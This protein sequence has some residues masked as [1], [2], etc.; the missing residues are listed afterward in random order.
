MG[1]G[2][3]HDQLGRSTAVFMQLD[4]V[5]LV[6]KSV[7]LA[8]DDQSWALYALDDFDIFKTFTNQKAGERAKV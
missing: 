1:H 5:G 8:M 7:C 4:C 3:W 2:S 6:Q